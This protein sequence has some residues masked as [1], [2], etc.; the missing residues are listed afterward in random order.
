MRIDSRIV[1]GRSSPLWIATKPNARAVRVKRRAYPS[2]L[3]DLPQRFPHPVSRSFSLVEYSFYP[4]STA[5]II[6][7]TEFNLKEN[8]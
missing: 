1:S 6:T 3:Q 4:L 5:P 2:F 8:K 7:N